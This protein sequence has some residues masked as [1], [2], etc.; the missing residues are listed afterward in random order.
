MNIITSSTSFVFITSP[1][2][3]PASQV[4]MIWKFKLQKKLKEN[5]D[6]AAAAAATAAADDDNDDDDD[7]DDDEHFHLKAT[8][9]RIKKMIYK[10]EN[11]QWNGSHI[12]AYL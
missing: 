6:I 12:I 2:N 1:R 7:D 8:H 5:K 11:A 4:C 10:S 9:C 3:V